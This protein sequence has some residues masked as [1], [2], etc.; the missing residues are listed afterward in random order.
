M[1]LSKIHAVI[2]DDD[3]FKEINIRKALEFNGIRNITA[4]RNQKKLWEQIYHGED[5]IDLIV[6]DMQYPLEAG[7]AVD[8]E[9]GFKLIERMEKEKIRIPVIVCSSLNYRIPDILGSVWYNERNDLNA[10]FKEVLG[11]LEK[12]D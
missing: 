8:K 7:E 2:A 9:A 5:K 11:K 4:V 12:D 10:K 6:T 1:E 3:V